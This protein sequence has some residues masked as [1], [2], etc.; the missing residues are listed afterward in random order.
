[1]NL[2]LNQ[3]RKHLFSADEWL[4]VIV[5]VEKPNPTTVR[6]ALEDIQ[7]A[8]AIIQTVDVEVS[9]QKGETKTIDDVQTLR[10]GLNRKL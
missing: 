3:V 6:N 2:R 1:M 4:K 8:L 5:Y 10:D 7:K 9:G